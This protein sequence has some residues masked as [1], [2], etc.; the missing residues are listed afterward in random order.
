M[1]TIINGYWQLRYLKVRA[2][3]LERELRNFLF[4][5]LLLHILSAVTEHRRPWDSAF[6]T[7]E[8]SILKGLGSGAPLW[9]TISM[10]TY[11]FV[12]LPKITNGWW[13][14]LKGWGAYEP[15]NKRILRC[16]GEV[17]S[18]SVRELTSSCITIF[19]TQERVLKNQVGA[20][21]GM[22]KLKQ[23]E[24]GHLRGH[25]MYRETYGS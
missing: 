9:N 3:F 18:H 13:K 10:K 25:W 24:W 21:A 4:D 5:L 15:V 11:E 23:S 6:L 7:A 12:S 17:Q 16:D 1:N 14:R 19:W 22:N 2:G 8:V 20:W